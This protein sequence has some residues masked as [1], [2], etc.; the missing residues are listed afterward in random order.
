M[1]FNYFFATHPIFPLALAGTRVDTILLT[2][3]ENKKNIV[4]GLIMF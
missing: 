2:T 4:Y 3:N 1:Y